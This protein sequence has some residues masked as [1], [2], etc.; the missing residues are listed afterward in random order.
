MKLVGLMCVKNEAWILGV[1]ARVAL[2]WCD[3]IVVVD[4]SSTD[5]TPQVIAAVAAE[6]PGRVVY[7]QWRDG[8]AWDE[9]EMR[10]YSLTLG[11]KAGGTHFAVIDADELIAAS[12]IPRIRRLVDN[13]APGDLIDA[14]MIPAW[15]SLTQY[16]NDN[17]IWSRGIISLAFADKPGLTWKPQAD[18]YEHHNRPPSGIKNRIRFGGASEGI[19]HAQWAN[20][21]RVLEKHVHYRMMEHVRWPGRM[22]TYE[23]NQKYDQAL[24]EADIKISDMPSAWIEPYADL[25]QKYYRP[26]KHSWYLNEIKRLIN[27]HGREAFAGLD[28]KGMA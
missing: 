15:R 8:G 16:R 14:S 9:M 3:E 27:V 2:K 24:N 6:H 21:D 28:L 17:S 10:E 18:G 12:F 13:L 25:I 20:W 5:D 19:I 26:T 11:R 23:L 1:S 7:S 22:S 4:H